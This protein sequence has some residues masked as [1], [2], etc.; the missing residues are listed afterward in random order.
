MRSRYSAFAFGLESYLLD[1][2]DPSTRPESLDID[3]EVD[4]RRLLV[5]STEA[6]GPFDREGWV[7]FTAIARRPS[8]RLVQRERSR[9]VRSPEG[10]W[11]YV[12]G[13]ALDPEL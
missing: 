3:P 7:A 2:W 11:R 8:G 9:F 10:R 4:W 6:G 12:D 1:S 13:V 5:E